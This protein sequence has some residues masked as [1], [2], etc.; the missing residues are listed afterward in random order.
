MDFFSLWIP[1]LAAGGP[2]QYLK[3]VLVYVSE[4]IRKYKQNLRAGTLTQR[5]FSLDSIAI[6]YIIKQCLEYVLTLKKCFVQVSSATAVGVF[7]NQVKNPIIFRN[8]SRR[9][10]PIDML[11]K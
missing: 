4:S 1:P 6:L 5:Y 7:G 11:H 3:Y 8:V 9:R 10:V 2:Y